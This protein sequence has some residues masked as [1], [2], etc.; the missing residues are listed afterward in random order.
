M[1]IHAEQFLVN[2]VFADSC[3]GKVMGVF[4]KSKARFWQSFLELF[5]Y[6]ISVSMEVFFLFLIICVCWQNGIASPMPVTC[7]DTAV[8]KAAEETLDQINAD[9][10]GGYILSLNRLYDFKQEIKVR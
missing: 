7:Q 3:R 2:T 5:R 10:Q 1:H 8:V 9:R 4:Y 6:C